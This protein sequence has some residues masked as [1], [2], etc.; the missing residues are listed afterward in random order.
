MAGGVQGENS[1]VRAAERR[2]FAQRGHRRASAVSL[3]I[4][5]LLL[6]V[7]A[8]AA[9]FRLGD[10]SSPATSRHFPANCPAVAA[11]SP[12]T[13]PRSLGSWPFHLIA[14][15]T[16]A[17]IEAGPDGLIDAL[18]SCGAEESSLRLVEMTPSGKVVSSSRLFPKAALLASSFLVE[19]KTVF[20][21]EARLSLSQKEA[22]AP[23]RLTLF[24]L[25]PRLGV[26]RSFS[27]GRGYGLSLVT[28]P[29]RT[30]VASTGQAL[31]TI[32]SGGAPFTL[33][34]FPGSV[35]Q[36][37]VSVAGSS[38]ALVSLFRPDAV[39]PSSSTS[40]DL[41][42][43]ATGVVPSSEALPAG[44]EVDSLAATSTA[45]FAVVGDGTSDALER[46]GGLSA[47]RLSR[48]GPGLTTTSLSS[49]TLANAGRHLYLAGLSELACLKS[50]SG[51]VLAGTSPR[52][53]DEVPSAFA[54]LGTASYAVV[55]AGLGRLSVPP[56]C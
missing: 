21:A 55:P 42:D 13:T 7:G 30:V 19:G 40:I 50:S 1:D 8:A 26:E 39:A 53:A 36:H 20:F 22:L 46:L 38:E 45:A 2:R 32:R 54:Q 47:L 44:E 28:G 15:G 12:V 56:E 52:S 31:V 3:S 43:L 24:E 9:A 27:L 17:Q 11:A 5:A 41:V 16:F 23:Y 14:E 10:G 35:V 49:L 33:A 34:S 25:G 37:I 29:E 4:V 6:V 18:Q 51:A 48:S